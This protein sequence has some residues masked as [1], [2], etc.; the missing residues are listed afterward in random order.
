[1][2][3]LPKVDVK[4][5]SRMCSEVAFCPAYW[6]TGPKASKDE[7]LKPV[8]GDESDLVM[9]YLVGSK[10]ASPSI[11]TLGNLALPVIGLQAER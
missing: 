6:I 11:N 4:M 10:C 1:M 5:L 8:N 7:I 9:L 3:W 2:R